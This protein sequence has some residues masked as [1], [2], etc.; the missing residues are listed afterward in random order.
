MNAPPPRETVLQP[1]LERLEILI[2]VN[3]DWRVERRH[4]WKSSPDDDQSHPGSLI[5]A[6]LHG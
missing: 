1:P 2:A 4:V 5:L 6:L 3:A